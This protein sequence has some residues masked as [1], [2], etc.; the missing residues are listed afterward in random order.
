MQE[1]C[2]GCVHRRS[3]SL[4]WLLSGCQG[5]PPKSSGATSVYSFPAPLMRKSVPPNSVICGWKQLWKSLDSP[6]LC[7]TEGVS[8]WQGQGL[9]ETP[10]APVSLCLQSRSRAGLREPALNYNLFTR[11]VTHLLL[12]PSTSFYTL[13]HFAQVL[14]FAQCL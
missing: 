2:L 3:M 12:F 8:T 9:P 14:C 6:L 13:R 5:E 4:S 11:T 7:V 10:E 1:G